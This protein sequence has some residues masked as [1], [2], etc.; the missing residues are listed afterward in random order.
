MLFV[1]QPR[2][3]LKKWQD[4]DRPAIAEFNYNP[5]ATTP[6]DPETGKSEY[7]NFAYGYVSEVIVIDVDTETGHVHLVDVICADDVGKAINPQQVVGQ[8]EGCVVQA[9]GYT[10]LENFIQQTEKYRRLCSPIT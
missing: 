8:I 1:A 7:P 2:L 6:Y 3:A 5:P 10:V 9:A 4:E